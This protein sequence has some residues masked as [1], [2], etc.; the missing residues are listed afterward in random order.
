MLTKVFMNEEMRRKKKAKP[1]KRRRAGAAGEG[2][3]TS[4]GIDVMLFHMICPLGIGAGWEMEKDAGSGPLF[5]VRGV[6]MALK[7]VLSAVFVKPEICLY[8]LQRGKSDFFRKN[9]GFSW[10]WSFLQ[11]S[12]ALRVGPHTAPK[13]PSGYAAWK[14]RLS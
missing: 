12:K 2:K 14:G 3:D 1:R 4:D 5:C 13:V 8:G 10:F 6:K 7:S 9:E 11:S